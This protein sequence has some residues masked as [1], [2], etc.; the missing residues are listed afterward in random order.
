MYSHSL[1]LPLTADYLSAQNWSQHYHI[2]YLW[3]AIATMLFSKHS[4]CTC[5]INKGILWLHKDAYLIQILWITGAVWTPWIAWWQSKVCRFSRIFALH[6]FLCHITILLSFHLKGES[7]VKDSEVH[8]WPGSLEWDWVTS[9]TNS[10]TFIPHT[11][12]S[13]V[14]EQGLGTFHN[15]PDLDKT[16]ASYRTL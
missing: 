16:W 5:V 14:L 7:L 8:K 11:T 2:L 10:V 15:T 13:K 4:G 6:Y 3:H 9:Y 12:L 1:S